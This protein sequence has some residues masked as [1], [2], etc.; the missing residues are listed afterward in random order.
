MC[1]RVEV[2]GEIE[3]V[4]E[5]EEVERL[6]RGLHLYF[7]LLTYLLQEEVSRMKASLR[8]MEA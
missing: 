3:A 1:S 2:V 7:T 6:G 4:E 5:V 8:T